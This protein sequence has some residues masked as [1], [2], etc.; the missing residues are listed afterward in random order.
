MSPLIKAARALLKAQSGTDDWDALDE[1]L[2][3]TLVAEA[4]AVI[5][6]YLAETT[7]T[8]SNHTPTVGE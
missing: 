1:E 4:R 8:D 3:A 2:Q 5:E 7:E 6:A